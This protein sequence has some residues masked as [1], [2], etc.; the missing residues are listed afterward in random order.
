MGFLKVKTPEIYETMF[1]TM[2][3]FFPPKSVVSDFR[4]LVYMVYIFKVLM[5]ESSEADTNAIWFLH[6]LV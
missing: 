3:Y 2:L 4:L 1:L 5:S 6:K